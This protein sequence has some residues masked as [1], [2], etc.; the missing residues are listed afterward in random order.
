MLNLA[1]EP[2]EEPLAV[3]CLGAHADDLEIG[4]GVTLL[5]LAEIGHP[6]VVTCVVFSAQ[7]QR[8]QEARDSAEVFLARA[9][10]RD[11]AVKGFRDGF[12]PHQGQELRMTSRRST[13]GSTRT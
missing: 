5:K 1:F 12:S 3:L 7:G 11:I 13:R 9:K 6:V 8:Q 4:C 10:T 2:R